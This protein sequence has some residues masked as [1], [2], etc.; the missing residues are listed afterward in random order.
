VNSRAVILRSHLLPSSPLPFRFIPFFSW[1]ARSSGRGRAESTQV[2]LRAG[3]GGPGRARA[4]RTPTPAASWYR[5][6]FRNPGLFATLCLNQA[7][8]EL[9]DR[10]A[11]RSCVELPGLR[12]VKWFGAQ[13]QSMPRRERCR[14]RTA[15]YST[16]SCDQT[17]QG[18]ISKRC[19]IY[20]NTI[21]TIDNVSRLTRVDSGSLR[22]SG[23]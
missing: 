5:L 13:R 12:P 9:P 16:P 7:K 6:W 18:A 1:F 22:I 19:L 4:G 11:L 15:F 2:R 3:L 21:N 20:I 8:A 17:F 10:A 14:R 23:Y